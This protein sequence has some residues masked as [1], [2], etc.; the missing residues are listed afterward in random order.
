MDTSKMV[1]NK[2]LEST[3]EEI[4]KGGPF[5]EEYKSLFNNFKNKIIN[6][7]TPKLV[8]NLSLNG[9]LFYGLLQEYASA[10]YSGENM[11]VES[12]LSNIV[13]SNLGEITESDYIY[14]QIIAFSVYN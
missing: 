4:N 12:P 14:R 6:N 8:K 9:N 3:E 2:Y 7:C 5:N 11:F 10:I 13:F 1:E